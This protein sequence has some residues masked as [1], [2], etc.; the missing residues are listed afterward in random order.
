MLREAQA[1]GR[2]LVVDETRHTGGVGEGIVT[3]LVE[4]G[5]SGSISRVASADSFVPL[6]PAANLVLVSE[7]DVIS[8]A[9]ALMGAV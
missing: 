3:A 5:F 2:V 9:R 8:A 6:G 4:N 7:D 1:T